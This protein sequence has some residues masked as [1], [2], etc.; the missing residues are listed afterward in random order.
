MKIVSHHTYHDYAAE[1]SAEWVNSMPNLEES[2]REERG[3]R[4]VL[5]AG[6]KGAFWYQ[7][8]ERREDKPT[9]QWQ[10][11]FLSQDHFTVPISNKSV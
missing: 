5:E 3:P 1:N 4:Y 7:K 10:I 11:R 6:V 9:N 2:P 8:S